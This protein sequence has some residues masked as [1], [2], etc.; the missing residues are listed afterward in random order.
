MGAWSRAADLRGRGEQRLRLVR[1]AL[2]RA[3]TGSVV[4]EVLV[5]LAV[6]AVSAVSLGGADGEPPSPSVWWTVPLG[7]V[8]LARWVW[9]TAALVAAGALAFVPFAG[10]LLCT[11]VVAF[12]AGRRIRSRRRLWTAAVGVSVAI[13]ALLP[14]D[15][16]EP[17]DGPV[18]EL[19]LAGLALTV[20]LVIAPA[21][22]GRVR[23]RRRPLVRL[24]SER[25]EHLERTRELTAV[26]ARIEERA[27]I[28]GELHDML[29]HRLGLLSMHAG[30]LELRA[31]RD[32]PA[33]GEQVRFVRSTAGA[34]MQD[35]RR[36]LRLAPGGPAGDARLVPGATPGTHDDVQ[37]LVVESRRA[38]FDVGFAWHG[39]DL[40]GLDPHTGHAVHRVVREGLTNAHKH[41]P[42]APGV[43]V[44]VDTLHVDREDGRVRVR[45][46]NAA[47][48]TPT[49]AG[50][51]TGR[52]LAGLEERVT[53]LGGTLAAGPAGDGGYELVAEIPVR[54]SV[55]E[56][57]PD[58]GL[59]RLDGP[60]PVRRDDVMTTGRAVAVVAL[61]VVV[62]ALTALVLVALLP[63]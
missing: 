37:A 59:A 19:L 35:L 39:A 36:I 52:G 10:G 30:A 63:G 25:N 29:G 21:A 28:T 55:A 49:A 11:A 13:T 62:P 51:G 2:S 17:R 45:V 20:V 7:V 43:R 12:G 41:A 58:L 46:A 9:P 31:A 57:V 6:G 34:A 3:S 47:P 8:L 42:G 23:G 4:R 61:A 16:S 5:L 38:G 27:R 1:V 18:W 48:A 44:E 40:V 32:A 14:F 33:L 60:P 24:L 56:P 54:P 26:Q 50:P 15:P 22:C 53:L